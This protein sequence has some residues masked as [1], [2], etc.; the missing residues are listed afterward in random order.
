MRGSHEG[1]LSLLLAV[2]HKA[3]A[4]CPCHETERDGFQARHAFAV[5]RTEQEVLSDHESSRSSG[6]GRDAIHPHSVIGVAN[7]RGSDAIRASRSTVTPSHI[8]AMP[9]RTR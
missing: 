1:P 8:Q 3:E 2:R 6:G 7:A 5:L 4:I 9:I